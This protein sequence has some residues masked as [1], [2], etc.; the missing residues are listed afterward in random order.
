MSALVGVGRHG[1]AE[2]D[3]GPVD[4]Q[5]QLLQPARNL[6]AP[7]LVAEVAADLAD[8]GR[9]GVAGELAAARGSYP[10]TAF[11]RPTM[12]TWVRSSTGSPRS[13][14]RRA[15]R[16]AKAMLSSMA[17][18]RSSTRSGE[19]AG[20]S[21]GRREQAVHGDVAAAGPARR[22]SAAARGRLGA[23]RPDG[24]PARMS[25][26]SSYAPSRLSRLTICSTSRLM[27]A[28][29]DGAKRPP[30]ARPGRPRR[31]ACR[32]RRRPAAAPGRGRAPAWCRPSAR[33]ARA[34]PASAAWSPG[35]ARPR[36]HQVRFSESPY[37][38][39]HAAPSPGSL[40]QSCSSC[41]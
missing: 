25:A 11:T 33:R 8:D 26:G 20:S 29:A 17:W 12:A 9:G 28:G 34:P 30:P 16:W 40:H 13:R 6:D 1:L 41:V 31:P 10:S 19:P 36:P 21:D 5:P 32:P 35:R 18:R 24:E 23:R 27:P 3:P 2:L 14:K 15:S 4:L 22:E 37:V 39:P 38:D 7:A